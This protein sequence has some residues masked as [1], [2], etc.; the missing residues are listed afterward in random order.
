MTK[1][2]R[3]LLF[4]AL[5]LASAGIAQPAQAV[6]WNWP[7]GQIP[8]D[9]K[10]I[11]KAMSFYQSGE[12]DSAIITLN[13]IKG[14]QDCRARHILADIYREQKRYADAKRELQEIHGIETQFMANNSARPSWMDPNGLRLEM[15]DM[16]LE[17]GETQE[18]L[19]IYREVVQANPKST[20][21]RLSIA[22]VYESKGELEEAKNSYRS[23]I[24]SGIPLYTQEKSNILDS[25]NRLE[26]MMEHQARGADQH[27]GQHPGQ[28]GQGQMPQ[29]Q[30]PPGQMPQG[31]YPPGQMGQY[32]PGQMPPG[33][34]PGQMGQ[35]QYPGQMPPPGYPSTAVNDNYG[36]HSMQAAGSGSD[37]GRAA[38]SKAKEGPLQW[39]MEEIAA[40]KYDDAILRLKEA[41]KVAPKNAQAHYLLAIAYANT[42]KY[43]EAKDEYEA[44]LKFAQDTRLKSMANGGLTKLQGKL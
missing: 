21:A 26:K 35:G 20:Q 3:V 11:E 17:Q 33:Q 10:A 7:A 2:A 16:A 29:G 38:A 44:V 39:A 6:D 31:Q 4:S 36:S 28:Q 18:A 43:K 42:S 15:G 30:Y 37:G 12:L 24:D 9:G 40:K 32:P 19:A 14:A 23:I 25:I 1:N 13:G 22:R 5:L 41:L 34:Y 8:S 27:Q